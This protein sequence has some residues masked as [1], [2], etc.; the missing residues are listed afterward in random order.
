MAKRKRTK[1]QTL[2]DI[3]LHRKLK[4]EQYEPTKNGSELRSSEMVSSSSSV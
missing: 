1:K 2:V 4:I 3:P